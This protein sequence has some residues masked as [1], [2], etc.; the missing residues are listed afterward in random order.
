MGSE[1][2]TAPAARAGNERSSEYGCCG[3]GGFPLKNGYEKVLGSN[4]MWGQIPE[5]FLTL[6]T[7]RFDS[8]P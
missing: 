3:A 8:N 5:I 4:L 6:S 7:F 1:W 2:A